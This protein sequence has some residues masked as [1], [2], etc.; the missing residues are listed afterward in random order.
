M[1]E[2]QYC[3]VILG[4]SNEQPKSSVVSGA[5]VEIVKKDA[6]DL[7]YLNLKLGVDGRY[8]V[9]IKT[10]S[11]SPIVATASTAI[12]CAYSMKSLHCTV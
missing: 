3:M 9:I 1:S 10:P 6:L 5:G 2:S 12:T 8:I 4:Y 11:F 7:F